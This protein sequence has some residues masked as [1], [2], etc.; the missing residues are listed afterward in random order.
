M[1]SLR[2]VADARPRKGSVQAPR[3]GSPT[4]N[5]VMEIDTVSDAPY[6]SAVTATSKFPWS[7]IPHLAEFLP[8]VISYPLSQSHLRIAVR[9]HF[10]DVDALFPIILMVIKWLRDGSDFDWMKARPSV[11]V[12]RYGKVISGGART[13]AAKANEK[14]ED[15]ENDENEKEKL[16]V[17]S[18]LRTE[19]GAAPVESVSATHNLAVMDSDRGILHL[20]NLR[21]D[22]VFPRGGFGR[23]VSGSHPT[24]PREKAHHKHRGGYQARAR[25]N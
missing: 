5:N 23:L 19:A 14:A 4:S 2:I 6:V 22:A 24:S 17:F 12:D 11:R 18:V 21:P 1:R 7:T 3:A 8:A 9:N 16:N 13:E 20:N 10:S 15:N 25:H